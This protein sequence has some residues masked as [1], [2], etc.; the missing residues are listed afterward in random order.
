MINYVPRVGLI[1]VVALTTSWQQVL[2]EAQA[3]SVRGIKV[4]MR[5][6]QNEAPPFFDLAFKA[7]P[8]SGVSSGDGYT[9]TSGMGLGDI[10]APSNGL[11][12]KVQKS[13][14]SGKLLEIVT[15]N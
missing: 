7:A 1:Y 2:T 9:T 4:K 12:A 5:F 15:Y 3:K 8:D 14:D 10:I 13:A 11:W 6:I